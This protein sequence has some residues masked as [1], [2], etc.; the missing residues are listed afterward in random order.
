[1]LDGF[2]DKPDNAKK[3]VAICAAGLLSAVIF[4]VWLRMTIDDTKA[5]LRETGE[6]GVALWDELKENVA[7]SYE[8]LSDRV[9]KVKEQVTEIKEH[10]VE[11]QSAGATGQ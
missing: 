10:V 2:K 1:M 5:A 9:G 11:A 8:S 7:S 6:E 3:I 4:V